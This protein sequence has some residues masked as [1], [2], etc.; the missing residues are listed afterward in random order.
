MRPDIIIIAIALICSGCANMVTPTGGKKDEK[1]PVLKKTNLTQLNFRDNYIKLQFDENVV[2][3][4]PVSLITIQPKHTTLDINTQGRAIRITFDSA[5][6]KNTT[7]TLKI[8]RSIKDVNE[9][10][11][12]SF[13]YTFSTGDHIDT[14]FIQYRIE[15]SKTAKNLKIGLTTISPDSLK[16]LKFDYLYAIT[17][18]NI[19]ISGLSGTPYKAWIFTDADN[20][21][22]PDE[23]APVFYDTISINQ[24]KS[25]R[26]NNWIDAGNSKVKFYSNCT[27]VFKA[28]ND[29]ASYSLRNPVYIDKDSSLFLHY[30]GDTLP[31]LNIKKELRSKIEDRIIGIKYPRDYMIAIDKCGIKDL[32]ITDNLNYKENENY[33][34]INSKTRIDSF[35]FKLNDSITFYCKLNQFNESNKISTLKINKIPKNGMII[36]VVYKDGKEISIKKIDLKNEQVFYMVPGTYQLEFYNTDSYYDLSFDFKKLSRENAALIKK[37]ITLKPNWDEDLQLIFH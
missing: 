32:K 29:E 13:S 7:Y 23:Y 22:I 2:L 16:K 10:N 30:N 25:I 1:I 5:L 19:S 6:H 24:L 15:D 21:D 12:Y 27:K 11:T 4:N 31:P 20:N 9:G 14:N 3:D 37:E 34:Y 33:Y 8:D 17:G 28:Q 36:M 35:N 26:L 18:D